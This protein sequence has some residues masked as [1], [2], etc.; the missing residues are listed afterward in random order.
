MSLQTRPRIFSRCA[1]LASSGDLQPPVPIR[2]TIIAAP[3]EGKRLAPG[4]L[5]NKVREDILADEVFSAIQLQ[6]HTCAS[7][8]MLLRLGAQ[9]GHATEKRNNRDAKS[10]NGGSHEIWRARSTDRRLFT[11]RSSAVA[12][13]FG[14]CHTITVRFASRRAL[15]NDGC[16]SL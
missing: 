14:N 7:G 12:V 10:C 13:L 9:I 3:R 16:C 11:Y 4:I 5:Q 1:I 6:G 8:H 2:S 15:G